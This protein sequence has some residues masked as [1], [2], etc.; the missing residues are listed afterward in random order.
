[1]FK[2]IR[3]RDRST[4]LTLYHESN[5]IAITITCLDLVYSNAE[6]S[7]LSVSDAEKQVRQFWVY[8]TKL[9]HLLASRNPCEDPMVQKLLCFGPA[10][11]VDL[12]VLRP[13]SG[14]LALVPPKSQDEEG[15]LSKG[16]L[17]PLIMQA[18]RNHLNARVASQ[19]QW[20]A[21]LKV[22]DVCMHFMVDGRCRS[23]DECSR[24][25][26][27]QLY[28]QRITILLLQIC[29]YQMI[30][31]FETRKECH[32]RRRSVTPAMTISLWS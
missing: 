32:E 11:S 24:S 12:F 9:Q 4:L 18:I 8:C 31:G 28:R 16:V 21:G 2:A 13:D 14:L 7:K 25:H 22:F 19:N 5:D 6:A 17:R 15:R 23:G 10:S 3:Q 20:S 29:I 26:E 30:D 1:M 27:P